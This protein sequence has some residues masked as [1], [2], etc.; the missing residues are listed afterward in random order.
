[1]LG[2]NSHNFD[3]LHLHKPS[4]I[5]YSKYFHIKTNIYIIFLVII[6]G[7][8]NFNQNERKIILSCINMMCVVSV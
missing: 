7:N 5:S 4:L 3:N 8:F 2:L 1:M 6:Y